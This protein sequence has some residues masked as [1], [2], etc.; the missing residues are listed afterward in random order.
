[1]STDLLEILPLPFLI[2]A[3][4]CAKD[5]YQRSLPSSSRRLVVT[6][7]QETEITFDLDFRPLGL[8]RITAYVDHPSASFFQPNS[9]A[10]VC[11]RLYAVCDF[12]LWLIGRDCQEKTFAEAQLG[13]RRGVP[14]AA[15]LAE[16]HGYGKMERSR[17]EIWNGMRSIQASVVGPSNT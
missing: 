5:H 17:G 9:A 1:M 11:I 14:G 4:A 15:P 13:H 2:V 12:F 16:L 8:R 7:D 6:L 3:G 10:K